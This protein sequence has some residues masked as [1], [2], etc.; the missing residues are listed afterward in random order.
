MVNPITYE[1]YPPELVG[2]RRRLV[3]GKLSGRHAIK[4]KLEEL[5][6]FVSEEELTKI[7]EAVKAASEERKSALSDEQFLKLI[8][9]VLGRGR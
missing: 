9:D 6:I 5:G 3:I 8:E 2:Q 7:T 1:P 4:A